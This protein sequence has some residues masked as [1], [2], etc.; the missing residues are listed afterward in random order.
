[1][2]PVAKVLH[3]NWG[4]ESGLMT[5]VHAYTN[6]QSILDLPHSDLYRARA[7]AHNIIPTSTGAAKA[8]GKVLPEL[9]GKLDGVAMRVPTPNVSL[10]DLKFIASRDTTEDEVNS[11]IAKYVD[12]DLDGVL[13]GYDEPLVSSDFNHNPLSSVFSYN[14]TKVIDGKLVRIMSW[15]DN[16]W[17][18]SNR[19][20]D[21]S[22]KMHAVGYA[23]S[24]A[25]AAE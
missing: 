24:T 18:F 17:G 12:G 2:A 16:E 7:A 20:L 21:T 14:G 10:V 8:V 25:E 19:M 4:I 6:D 23:R 3:D 1:M 15:Y 13:G 11:I 22:A 5:T 9:E